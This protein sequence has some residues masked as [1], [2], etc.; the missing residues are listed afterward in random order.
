MLFKVAYKDKKSIQ[1]YSQSTWVF[2][3]FM[4]NIIQINCSL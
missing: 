4:L 3:M 1:A 2:I